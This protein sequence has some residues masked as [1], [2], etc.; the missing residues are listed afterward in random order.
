VRLRLELVDP[1][2]AALDALDVDTLA[3]FVGAERPLT[4]LPSLLD[5][6]LAGAV[7]RA[8][9]DGL[10]TPEHGEAL[11]L[12][13]A[14]KLRAGR[15]VLFGVDDPSP[16]SLTMAVRRGCESLRRA[17]AKA[18]GVGLPGGA[19]V[20]VAARAWVEPAA[21]AGFA[22]QVMIGD[23]RTLGPALEAAARE[24]GIAAE[25]VRPP[26]R[27]GAPTG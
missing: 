21:V 18:V 15:V 13:S 16:R 11:L 7:S 14:G 2:L 9:L 26:A 20:A 17:G 24:L 19:S 10:V 1:T 12:P 23:A 4:G 27:T 25:I 22:R 3:A 6:R 5:W 8:I